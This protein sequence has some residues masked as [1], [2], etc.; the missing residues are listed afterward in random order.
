MHVV[1]LAM[2]VAQMSERNTERRKI[3]FMIVE[4]FIPSFQA[5]LYH[6]TLNSNKCESIRLKKN[7]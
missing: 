7:R 3:L 1:A 6:S 2:P 4:P 5:S